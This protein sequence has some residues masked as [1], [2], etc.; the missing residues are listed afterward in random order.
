[1]NKPTLRKR[2]FL[3]VLAAATT[4]SSMYSLPLMAEELTIPVAS[5]AADMQ[6][7]PRPKTGIKAEKVIAKF[8]EPL[9]AKPAVGEPPISRWEYADFYVYFEYNHV[10]HSVL[11]HKK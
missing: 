11:K 10:V 6:H 2:V 8:G 3:P 9:A 7:I 1:M 5:Q 4:I